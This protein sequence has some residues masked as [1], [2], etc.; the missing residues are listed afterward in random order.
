MKTSLKILS[1]L[2]FFAFVF[3]SC[4]KGY[5]VRV[6][7]RNIEDMDSVI[8]GDKIVFENITRQTTSEYK[9]L[10]KGTYRITFVSKTKKRTGSSITIPKT[11]TGKRTI[12]IDGQGLILVLKD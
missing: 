8:I 1:L 12:Q 3:S 5:E 4:G 2:L 6:T 11:K 10:A 7:N 9:K